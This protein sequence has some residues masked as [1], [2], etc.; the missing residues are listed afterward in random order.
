MPVETKESN[1]PNVTTTE[2]PFKI[3]RKE[4]ARIM[5]RNLK[6]IIRLFNL[7]LKDALAVSEI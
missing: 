4:F 6:G 1:D 3:T 5:R 7:E 2:A